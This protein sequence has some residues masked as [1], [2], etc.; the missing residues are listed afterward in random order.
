M[1]FEACYV[2]SGV[3]QVGLGPFVMLACPVIRSSLS[4]LSGSLQYTREGQQSGAPPAGSP[5]SVPASRLS[6]L[7]SGD[8]VSLAASS[9]RRWNAAVPTPPLSR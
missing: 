3:L 1:I 5:M 9:V 7:P 8:W 2:H 4:M 6:L